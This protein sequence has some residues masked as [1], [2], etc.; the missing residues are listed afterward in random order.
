V[1]TSGQHM[2]W[3]SRLNLVREWSLFMGRG[4]GGGGCGGGGGGGG[5]GLINGEN[6]D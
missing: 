3:F 6:K 1:A 4:G 2:Q 5:G